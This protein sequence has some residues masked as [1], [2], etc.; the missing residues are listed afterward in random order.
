MDLGRSDYHPDDI[1]VQLSANKL[2]VRVERDDSLSG[3]RS[4]IRRQVMLVDKTKNVKVAH[5]RLPS[6]E[7]RSRFR[8]LA[9]AVSLQ[10]T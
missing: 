6:V 7:F 5:T 10:V 2:L 1:S 3:V 9:L 8:F 4:S